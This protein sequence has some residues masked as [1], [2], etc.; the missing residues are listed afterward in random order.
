MASITNI[1]A[2]GLEHR[3]EENRAYGMARGLVSVRNANLIF[4][5]TDAGIT[6]VGEA[7]G[8]CSMVSAAL[9]LLK[10]YFIGRN[11][12][13]HSQV[14][15]YFY[16]QRYHLGIQNTLTSCLGGIDIAA[17]DAIGKLTNVPVYQLLG[18]LN[19]RRVPAYASD[20][21]FA[22]HPKGQLAD[23]LKA[24]R[25]KGF[26]GV[27]IK[28]GR[29]P[30]DDEER[31]S[32][33]RDALGPEVQLM[34]DVNGNYTADVAL[35]SMIRIQDYNVQFYEEPLTPTDFNGYATLHSRSPIPIATGEA[36]YTPHEFKRLMD[37]NGAD[38]WQP[39]L[40]LCGGL[41]AARE[42]STLAKLSHVRLSPHVWGGAI[43]LSAALHFLSA[44]VPWPHTD[45][46]PYAP[47]LEYDQGENAL[48][49]KLLTTPISCIDGHLVVPEGPGLGIDLNWDA[50]EKYR[51][52]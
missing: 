33:A 15:A 48:R 30:A 14:P 20:G 8:P 1:S 37:V 3:L 49:D 16:A 41:S 38:I 4:V 11:L 46:V 31:V 23:Q 6:G 5:E 27:K 13:D 45:N 50:V 25:D 17:H 34:V 12:Y 42:I 2:I 32:L 9:D 26:P 21:Y 44:Q 24:F 7:S 40:T 43:G 22:A 39:D 28:I 51:V 10:P 19:E 36:L 47:L 29:D 52:T 18:G 35:Q